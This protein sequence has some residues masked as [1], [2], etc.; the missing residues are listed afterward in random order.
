MISPSAKSRAIAA[1]MF[2]GIVFGS[3]ASGQPQTGATE[4]P[5]VYKK[6][7]IATPFPEYPFEARLH[8]LEGS[9]FISL[10]IDPEDGQVTCASVGQRTGHK[11]LGNPAIE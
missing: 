4:L 5:D 6:Y 11:I 3:N 7:S 8:R 1:V 10:T 2:A 9:G